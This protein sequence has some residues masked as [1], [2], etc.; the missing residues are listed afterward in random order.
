MSFDDLTIHQEGDVT[1]NLDLQDFRSCIFF[2]PMVTKDS[3]L[4]FHVCQV[5]QVPTG[6][7]TAFAFLMNTTRLAV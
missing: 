2:D 6:A 3:L 5:Y 7:L 4:S 1:S